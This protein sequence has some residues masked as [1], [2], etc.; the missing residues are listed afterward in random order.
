MKTSIEKQD[1]LEDLVILEVEIKA[2]EVLW[3]RKYI[4]LCKLNVTEEE[5]SD[6]GLSIAFD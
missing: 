4:E 2:K 1:L 5:L 3:R 6:Y